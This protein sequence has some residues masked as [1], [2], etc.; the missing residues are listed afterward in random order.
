MQE[1]VG[2]GAEQRGKKRNKTAVTLTLFPFSLDRSIISK[3]FNECFFG[4]DAGGHSVAA[5]HG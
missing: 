5:I 1:I 4:H 2:Q 3:R